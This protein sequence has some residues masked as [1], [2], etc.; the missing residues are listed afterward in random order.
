MVHSRWAPPGPAGDA[1]W[2]AG[3]SACAARHRQAC[4]R[5]H[6]LIA[7]RRGSKV[8]GA[9]ACMQRISCHTML[10]AGAQHLQ[11]R[12]SRRRSRG[13]GDE[14]T[15]RL[16][17][18]AAESVGRLCAGLDAGAIQQLRRA[19]ESM[20]LAPAGALGHVAQVVPI[21]RLRTSC[22][23]RERSGRGAGRCARVVDL[24]PR[25]GRRMPLAVRHPAWRS[26]AL[27]DGSRAVARGSR[28]ER[29]SEA[30]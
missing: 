23:A 1:Q 20:R 8:A 29:L 2:H 28:Q 3:L 6:T 22:A 11:R 10:E 4:L 13:L 12:S 15:A 21:A 26:F 17:A 18:G 19:A 25:R 14:L 30:S 9:L 16:R 27:P 5:E 24:R 7:G